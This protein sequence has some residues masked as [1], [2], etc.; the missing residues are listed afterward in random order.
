MR[1]VLNWR[2]IK[3]QQKDYN[4]VKVGKKFY[5]DNDLF[6]FTLRYND[7]TNPNMNLYKG[8]VHVPRE[9][10]GNKRALLLQFWQVLE[11]MEYDQSL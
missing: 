4:F 10:L 8:K 3:Q 11:F 7:A 2:L 6:N 5:K 1:C 9:N